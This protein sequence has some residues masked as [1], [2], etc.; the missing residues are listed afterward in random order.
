VHGS[1]SP[2]SPTIHREPPSSLRLLRKGG[3]GLG[4]HGR[5]LTGDVCALKAPVPDGQLVQRG[6]ASDVFGAQQVRRGGDDL[7]QTHC[8][9]SA[10]SGRTCR[11]RA[12]PMNDE[13]QSQKGTKEHG[14]GE[15]NVWVQR[16][17]NQ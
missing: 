2:L 17:I 13:Q 16:T 10:V 4:H 7:F 15:K 1:T 8:A 3:E 9:Q 12:D 14:G 11:R 6:D 5:E